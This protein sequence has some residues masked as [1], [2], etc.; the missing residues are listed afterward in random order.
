VGRTQP[1]HIGT[2]VDN[3]ISKLAPFN[4]PHKPDADTAD[5]LYRIYKL[6]LEAPASMGAHSRKRTFESADGAH[7][8]K[9]VCISQDALQHLATAGD[10]KTLRRAHALSREL[11]FQ[12]IFGP[13]ARVWTKADLMAYFFEHDTCALVT[14]P[15]NN[16]DTTDSWSRLHAVPEHILCKGSFAVYARKT[17]DVRWAKDLWASIQ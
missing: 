10:T 14:S 2:M 11:R 3:V 17:V 15:E 7:S 6:L 16:R 8:W 9:V 13:D 12:S 1:Y 4:R 5:F